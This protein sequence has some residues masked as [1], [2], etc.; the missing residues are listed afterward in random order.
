MTL[1]AFGSAAGRA[2]A[3]RAGR[4]V[5]GAV[6]GVAAVALL[7]VPASAD[8]AGDRSILADGGADT[9][10]VGLSL[11]GS[12]QPS[13]PGEEIVYRATV[14][15]DGEEAIENGLLAQHVP[16]PLEVVEL[17]QGG[18]LEEGVANWRVDVPAGG[19]AEYTVRVRLPESAPEEE[20]AVSTACLLLDRDA[21]PA[22]CASDTL[23]VAE[24]TM[25]SRMGEVVDRE[26]VLRA[27]G[28]GALMLLV[29]LLWRQW[30]VRRRG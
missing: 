29:W 24:S 23:L 30:G 17:G 27:V 11:S 6:T 12:A 25:L 7:A 14:A 5:V 2:G 21:E 3:P 1:I 9:A 26:G 22:A 13:A 8:R 19:E 20:R 18:V 28:V 10:L 16:E 15:N 4:A